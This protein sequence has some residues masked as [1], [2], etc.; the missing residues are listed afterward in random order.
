MPRYRHDRF[1]A[2]ELRAAQPE[3]ADCP[4]CVGRDGRRKKLYPAVEDA[5]HAA[6]QQRLRRGAHL[7]VYYCENGGGGW[8]LTGG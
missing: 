5:K 2:Q 6:A 7:A 3:F 4:F 1:I 8:H